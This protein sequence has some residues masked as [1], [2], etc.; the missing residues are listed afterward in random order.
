MYQNSYWKSFS[1]LEFFIE[2]K[3]IR[4]LSY[5]LVTRGLHSLLNRGCFKTS[6]II[7]HENHTCCQNDSNTRRCA[8]ATYACTRVRFSHNNAFRRA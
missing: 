2:S 6:T 3:L 5:S 1:L 4:S 7:N 8:G